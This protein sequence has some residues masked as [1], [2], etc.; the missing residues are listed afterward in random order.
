MTASDN[1][2]R[3]ALQ[4]VIV[5]ILFSAITLLGLAG[6]T[7]V[8]VVIVTRVRMRTVIN[9]LLLNLAVADLGFVLVIP[10]FTAY[11]YVAGEL[12]TSSWALGSTVCKLLHYLVNVTAYVT[13]L[14]DVTTSPIQH[15]P[16]YVTVYTLV[17]IAAVRYMTIVHSART[18][19]FRQRSRVVATLGVIWVG[20]LLV[21]TP[22]LG[23]YTVQSVGDAGRHDCDLADQSLGRPIFATFFAFAYVVPL[24]VIAVFSLL[25][26][27]HLARQRS[28]FVAIRSGSRQRRVTRLLVLIVLVFAVLWLPI[29]VHL[30]IAFFGDI[31]GNSP[32]YMTLS[33]VWNCLAYANSCVNPIIYNYTCKDFRAAFHSV[34]YS[35]CPSS[36]IRADEVT[37][38]NDRDDA[39]DGNDDD[40]EDVEPAIELQL[41]TDVTVVG[42][43]RPV[44]C[45]RS[46]A[47]PV[48]RLETS[49]TADVCS[50]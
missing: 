23:A 17:L 35:C 1:V 40:D 48:V 2:Y 21:N 26:L 10:P 34:V 30:L 29:H 20:M 32:V 12:P 41:R 38:V 18:A 11:E 4:A 3:F 39:D 50:V 33:V 14:Y 43:L 31:P 16:A 28:S 46:K 44:G 37:G 22:I 25:I 45:N 8:I 27:A 36:C 24:C 42:R 49:C 7:L 6:N 15:A 9:I 13:A 19:R 5:P 47:V